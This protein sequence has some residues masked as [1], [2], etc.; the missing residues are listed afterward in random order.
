MLKSEAQAITILKQNNGLMHT[1]DALKAGIHPRTLYSLRDKGIVTPI[2]RGIYRL[3]E[4]EDLSNPDL[5]TVAY[6]APNVVICLVSALAFHNI[7][8]QIPR[9]V[10]IATS[11]DTKP[12]KIDYPPISAHRFSETAYNV[13]VEEHVIDGIKIRIYNPEKT[14]SIS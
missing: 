13:G 8:T 14:I 7:T 3:T 10:Y 4:M 5:T 12:P 11:K 9:A 2:S 6:K 1:I